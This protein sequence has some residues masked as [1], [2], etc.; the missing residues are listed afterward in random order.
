[1]KKSFFFIVVFFCL[2]PFSHAIS[3]WQ[4]DV[5]RL[6]K[7]S[8]V[9][10][11]EKL[12]AKVV[13]ASPDWQDVA[14]HLRSMQFPEVETDTFLLLTSKCIDDVER[15]YV[16]YI[17]ASYYPGE[18][19]PLSLVLHGGISRAEISDKPMEWATES[20]FVR[21]AQENGW[22]ALYPFGQSGATWWD[23]VGMANVKN[24]IRT[25]KRKY[26]IDDDRIYMSGFS[27]GASASFGFAMV[28]PSDFA[29]FF[30]P[31]GHMGVFSLDGNVPTFAPNMYNSPVYAITNA[32]DG[33]YATEKMKPTIEMALDAGADITYRTHEGGHQLTY[34]DVE[35]PL[36]QNFLLRHPRDPIPSRIVWEAADK[37]FGRCHWFAIDEITTAE[38]EPWHVDHN[39]AMIDNRVTIGFM[40]D[41]SFEGEGV[42]VN[43]VIED[44]FAEDVGLQDGDI[45]VR[46]DDLKIRDIDDLNEFKSGVERGDDIRL[47]V[48]RNG[49]KVD[50]KGALPEPRLYYLFKREQPSAFAD[51]TA[52]GN[53]IDIKSSR[54]GAFRILVNPD[55]FRLEQNLVISVNGE[56]V[57]DEKVEPNIGF[58]LKDYLQSRDRKALYVAEVRIAL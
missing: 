29:A 27:D 30:A 6:I 3:G 21:L 55:L 5:D 52:Y 17:P 43:R 20:E 2:L 33:L 37:K 41:D 11:Q 23:D 39:V 4:D 34:W 18:P 28:D 45:I 16:V 42:K 40:N 58:M 46:A 54:L 38:P 9:T 15:P 7:E 50:L 12:I 14:H 1:M 26:N 47:I 53:R 24:L 56:V 51:V 44:T 19:T 57:F 22:L 49:D 25:M 36:V 35:K 31:N 8:S 32:N 13:R 48:Q 10:Q